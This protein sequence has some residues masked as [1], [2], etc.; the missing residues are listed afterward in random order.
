MLGRLDLHRILFVQV[1]HGDNVFVPVE[2][3]VVEVH[4]GI[5]RNH[6]TV[7]GEDQRID[8]RERRVGFPECLVQ[9]F[10]DRARLRYASLRNPDHARQVV[11]LRIGQALLRVDEYLV[12]FLRRVRRDLFDVH[13][14]FR[15]GHH[16]DFLRT[17]VHHQ[18][19]IQLLA[20]IGA[21]FDQQAPHLLAFGSGLMGL[22]LHA[23]DPGCPLANFID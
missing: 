6:V 18:A 3:V 4:L 14:A 2:R 5:Q 12:D 17:A 15:G 7:A 16:A 13:A 20:D 8:F 22:E 9:A 19:D 1:A 10:Q 21:F 11:S 23:E